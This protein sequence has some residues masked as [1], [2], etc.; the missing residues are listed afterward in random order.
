M[1]RM[2]QNR[3]GGK[4]V[5]EPRKKKR[6]VCLCRLGSTEPK[7][8]YM[9][10]GLCCQKGTDCIEKYWGSKAKTEKKGW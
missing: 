1:I 6:Q 8:H 10:V 9:L 5:V 3:V 4:T 2:S 7:S